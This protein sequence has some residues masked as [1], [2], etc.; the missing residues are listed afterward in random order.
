MIK[1][2]IVL[3]LK[4]VSEVQEKKI[5]QCKKDQESRAGESSGGFRE[6]AQG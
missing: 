1:K 3:S 2:Q 4:R 5:D 6:V